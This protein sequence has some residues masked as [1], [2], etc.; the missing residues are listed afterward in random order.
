KSLPRIAVVTPSYNQAAF[1][2]RTMRSVLEQDYPELEYIVLDGGSTDDSP[3]IIGRYASSLAYWESRKDNGQADAVARGFERS[4][5]EIL[6]YINSDDFYFPGAFRRAGEVFSTHPSVE[7]VIGRSTVVD[8]GETLMYNW[9]PPK[10]T[11][12]S[13]LFSGPYFHQPSSF[14]RR[15]AYDAV[16]GFDRSLHF[17]FDYD[18]FLRLAKRGRPYMVDERLASF[19]IHATSKTTTQQETC[20]REVRQ[21]RER[22][23]YSRY[24]RLVPQAFNFG[25]TRYVRLLQKLGA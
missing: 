12:R 3:K 22:F 9:R 17:A 21:L 5:A 16:G 10:V 11:Y 20:E 4:S 14:W 23:G 1:L 18:L 15:S 6:A 7:W 25:F 2:E 8:A 13:L 19:R 24:P